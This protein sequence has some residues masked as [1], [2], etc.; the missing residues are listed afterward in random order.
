[1]KNI[2][3]EKYKETLLNIY[4]Q[5]L[6]QNCSYDFIVVLKNQEDDFI[7]DNILYTNYKNFFNNHYLKLSVPPI[8]K[9]RKLL[10]YQEGLDILKKVNYGVLSITND[11]PYCVGLNHFIVDNH[12]YFHCGKQGYKLNGINKI[13]CYH[14]I[15]DLGIHVEVFT[16][17]H[18]SVVVYGT[19]KEVTENK[20]AL[21][22]AFL[23]RYTPGFTK[24]L[25]EAVVNNTMILELTI[26]HMTAKKHF[27]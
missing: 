9:P 10:T 5:S 24:D 15:E 12:I 3:I 2:L 6:L 20:K 11:I 8:R 17:N 23:K 7:E 1:M 25:T 16:N 27:H 14:V 26:D 21:L 4:E 19:L 13:A 18:N 22:E